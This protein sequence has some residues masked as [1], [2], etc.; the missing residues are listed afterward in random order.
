MSLFNHL[1]KQSGLKQ[2]EIAMLIGM[3]E[4]EITRKKKENNDLKLFCEVATA[5]N[6][7]KMDFKM[8]DCE[9]SIEFKK[10]NDIEVADKFNINYK[11]P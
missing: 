8:F 2:K 9:I 10:V 6:I 1:I 4:S 11:L 3:S 7:P 5:L